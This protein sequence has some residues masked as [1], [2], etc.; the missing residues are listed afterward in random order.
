VGK[1]KIWNTT[2]SRQ[3]N[4]SFTPPPAAP[5]LNTDRLPEGS[6]GLPCF[7]GT[8]LPVVGAVAAWH[9]YHSITKALRLLGHDLDALFH[10]LTMN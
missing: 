7:A 6:R 8:P 3:E 9:G 1:Q 10:L 4:T 2:S 5:P